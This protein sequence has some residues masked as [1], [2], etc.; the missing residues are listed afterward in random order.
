MALIADILVEA[1]DQMQ[2]AADLGRMRRC[3]ADQPPMA[4]YSPWPV[5]LSLLLLA[6]LLAAAVRRRWLPAALCSRYHRD[7]RVQRHYYLR[8]RIILERAMFESCS[9]NENVERN[10]S[11]SS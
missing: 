4:R 3:L 8:N 11:D 5:L 9:T 6:L 10:G 7:R 2:T 1:V